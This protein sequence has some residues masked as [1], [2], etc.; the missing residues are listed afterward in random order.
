MAGT[1]TLLQEGL[2]LDPERTEAV[3]GTCLSVLRRLVISYKRTYVCPKIRTAKQP[4]DEDS[5][6]SVA[7]L[8]SNR[9]GSSIAFQNLT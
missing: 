6:F 8:T 4:T 3:V 9:R 2:E 5:V 7:N 1:T